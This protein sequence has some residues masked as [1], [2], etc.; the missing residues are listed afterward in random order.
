MTEHK[1]FRQGS[2]ALFGALFGIY[3]NYY[4]DLWNNNQDS[5]FL[6]LS[7]ILLLT[8]LWMITKV[9]IRK[10]PLLTK[11][12]LIPRFIIF[13]HLIINILFL[14]GDF[15]DIGTYT[16]ILIFAIETPRLRRWVGDS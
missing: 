5:L 14:G 8:Y 13:I 7:A 1:E 9:E 6:P 11:W 10:A 3:G 15:D 2:W 12:A 4:I 16:L